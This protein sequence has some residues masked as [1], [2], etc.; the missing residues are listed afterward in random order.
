M[1]AEEKWNIWQYGFWLWTSDGN[2]WG[3]FDAPAFPRA[4][5]WQS[6]V[7]FAFI[8][9]CLFIP[10]V[11]R[12]NIPDL[13]KQRP[14]G[15]ND[16][17]GRKEQNGDFARLSLRLSAALTCLHVR[18]PL[19]TWWLS[20]LLYLRT[21]SVRRPSRFIWNSVVSHAVCSSLPSGWTRPRGA[22]DLTRAMFFWET[23]ADLF[24]LISRSPWWQTLCLLLV[25]AKMT[26][27]VCASISPQT[28]II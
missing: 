7:L 2:F 20:S 17:Q 26:V 18:V 15:G 13:N 5:T 14:E 25:W 3:T 27:T 16:C 11:F 12:F 21:N 8:C 6:V 19:T 4:G 28:R 23:T 24:F 1:C 9:L 22:L 10:H